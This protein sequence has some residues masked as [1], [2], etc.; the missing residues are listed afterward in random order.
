VSDRADRAAGLA[1]EHV[2]GERYVVRGGRAPHLVDLADPIRCDCKDYEFHPAIECK[3]ILAVHRF[4]G[5]GHSGTAPAPSA[6]ASPARNPRFA[7]YTAPELDELRDPVWTLHGILPHGGLTV[8]YGPPAGGKSFVALDW[9][10]SISTGRAWLG[11]ATQWGITIFVAAEGGRG[12]KVR[13]DAWCE[14]QGVPVADLH[15]AHFVLEPVNLMQ[16]DDVT[17]LLEDVRHGIPGRP[18]L[19][20]FDTL[21]G[22]MTGGD[23]NDT[24]D[25]ST[26]VDACRHITLTT[27]AGVLVLHHMSKDGRW[28]RGSIALRG[29]ADVMFK[30]TNEGSV[31]TLENDKQRDAQL[32]PTRRLRLQP[33]GASCVVEPDEGQP[34]P[35]GLSRFERK[36]LDALKSVSVNGGGVSH[37]DWKEA[38]ELVGGTWQRT[39]AA[40][41]RRGY[42]DKDARLY[43]LMAAGELAL[44]PGTK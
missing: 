6:T 2:D 14:A 1:V 15:A 5:N 41:M 34:L 42:V 30:L 8:L 20:V 23:E 27:G 40:L 25:M 22:C 37:A 3:H 39:R 11:H 29:G 26:F 17:A 21:A 33:R 28:E 4:C 38:S 7:L 18:S 9:S 13:R 31:L 16:S 43:K 24:R 44:V 36:A 12:L 35:D 19:F 10:L 32:A